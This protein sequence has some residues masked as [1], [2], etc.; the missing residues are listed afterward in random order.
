MHQSIVRRL[1]QARISGEASPKIDPYLIIAELI[2]MLNGL[3]L[4]WLRHP[5]RVDPDECFEDDLQRL[6]QSPQITPVARCHGRAQRAADHSAYNPC[7]PSGR[8]GRR[9]EPGACGPIAMR[10]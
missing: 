4:P 5:C 2:V 3:Q 7:S 8:K 6:Q 1:H 10:V 9:P